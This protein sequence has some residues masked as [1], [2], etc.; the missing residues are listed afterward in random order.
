MISYETF[1]NCFLL[2]SGATLLSGMFLFHKVLG[3]LIP[4]FN[5]VDYY[6]KTK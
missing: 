4:F 5:K 1:E 3:T 6:G 2:C